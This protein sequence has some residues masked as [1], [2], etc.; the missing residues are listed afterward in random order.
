MQG[1]TRNLVQCRRNSRRGILERLTSEKRIHSPINWISLK[2][3]VPSN[4]SK[5]QRGRARGKSWGFILALKGPQFWTPVGK[6]REREREAE[7]EPYVFTWNRRSHGKSEQAS[8]PLSRV[9]H[10]T[11]GHTHCFWN[12]KGNKWPPKMR[13]I[14]VAAVWHTEYMD[15]LLLL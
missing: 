11:R 7:H 13:Q 3:D 12:H 6:E 8:V 9:A 5:Y 15:I 14:M 2:L 1:L 4:W 10:A